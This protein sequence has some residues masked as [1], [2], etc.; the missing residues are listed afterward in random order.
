MCACVRLCACVCQDG[1]MRARSAHG[2]KRMR[3]ALQDDAIV[4]T[5]AS[6]TTAAAGHLEHG[7][8]LPPGPLR[9]AADSR[10]LPASR[11]ERWTLFRRGAYR[12]SPGA[13]RAALCGAI[14]APCGGRWLARP[15]WTHTVPRLQCGLH[16]SLSPSPSPVMMADRAG[17]GHL[18]PALPEIIQ[19]QIDGCAHVT[20][21]PRLQRCASR[22]ASGA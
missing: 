14:G 22:R 17:V 7:A 11:R 9:R 19:A 3:N 13:R 18:L 15:V 1:Y 21:I 12:A 8:R 10:P 20:G 5:G 16:P 4:E 2:L 6:T